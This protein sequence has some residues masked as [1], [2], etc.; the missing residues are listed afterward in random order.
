MP[1]AGFSKRVADIPSIALERMERE[2]R[3]C[4]NS[5]GAPCA[6]LSFFVGG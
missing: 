5:F 3:R 2:A 1:A 6:G 4:S